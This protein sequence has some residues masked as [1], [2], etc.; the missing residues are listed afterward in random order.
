MDARHAEEVRAC[1]L[2]GVGNVAV[3]FSQT[4]STSGEILLS[5]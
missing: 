5:N 3:I 4:S 1:A 2:D